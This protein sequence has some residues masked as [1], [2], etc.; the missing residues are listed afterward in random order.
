[1]TERLD[2]KI[3][4]PS[5]AA[6]NPTA[7]T[8]ASD[9]LPVI[10]S[11]EEEPYT[12]KC[13]CDYSDDD[14]NTIYC[15]SCDTWQH[16][17]CYYPGRVE[18]ASKDDFSHFCADCKPQ[19][20][21]DS[22]RATER[23][24]HNRQNKI[25]NDNGDKKTKRPPSKSHKKKSKPSELQVNGFVDHDSHR[26]GSP[27]EHHTHAKKTKGHR[28]NQSVSSA[29]KRS[30]PF[31]SRPHPHAHPPSPAHTPPDLP[32]TFQVHGYSEMFLSLYDHEYT[33]S[34]TNS[35]ASLDVTNSMSLWVHD[36]AKLEEDTRYSRE[37]VFQHLKVPIDSL[38]WQ[39]LRL[40]R[41]DGTFN[42]TA[43]H[44]RFLVAPSHTQQASR[45][46][47]LNGFIGFQHKYSED[48][49]ARWHEAP[50]PQ[51]F[52]FFH[53]RL[54]LYIDT[55]QEGSICR[56][57]RRSCRANASLET[58]I[59]ESSEYHFWLISE[60]QI[61]AGEQL[62]IPWD[63]RFPQICKSRYLRLLNL[64]DEDGSHSDNAE[65]TDEEYEGL[66][67]VIHLV[68]SDHGGCACDLGNDC[69]FARFHRSY[70]ARSHSQSNGV[71][72]KKSRKVKQNH[73]SPT[74][75]G[76]ATN[77]RAASEG[78]GEAYDEED[79]RSTSGSTR[80]K[81]QS[82]DLT[83]SH[84]MNETN[85]ILTEPTDREKRKLAML[86][87]SF[88]K[89]E[90]GQPP[91]KKK[92]VSDGSNVAVLIHT[93]TPQSKPRQKSVARM[94]ISQ[95]GASTANSQRARQYADASTSRRQSGSPFSAVSPTGAAHSPSNAASRN[96]SMAYQS[97][98]ASANPKAVYVDAETQ[99]EEVE[100]AWWTKPPT[101]PKRAVVPL[102]QRL[103]RNRRKIQAQQDIQNARLQVAIGDALQKDQSSPTIPMD[104][105]NLAHDDRYQTES[106]T[107]TKGR[108]VSISS[109]TTSVDVS[110]A[111]DTTM[112]DA[113]AVFIANQIKPPPPPWPH[114]IATVSTH[115]STSPTQRSPD[116][117]L[118]LPPAP[119][120][121]SPHISGPLSASA[122]PSSASASLTQSPF[123]TTFP[124]ASI[125]GL[126]Q[127]AS[128][129]KTTKK[130]SL[131]DYRAAR[132]RKTDT[133][134][135]SKP[136]SGSSPT[137]IPASLKPSLSTIEEVKAQ[138][139]LEG[140]AIVDSPMV[141]RTT[142]PLATVAATSE[143]GPK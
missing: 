38:K 65:I 125:N 22:R 9:A 103:L 70:H 3:A 39:E 143:A 115:K 93:S 49:E 73:V 105:D 90:Q 44:W 72:T 100:N 134:N 31:S 24:K 11:A 107:D 114:Q 66:S 29:M 113:P 74:S 99:T 15:E 12:I 16:T 6:Y 63:F 86:E 51:P 83:P 30:P 27:Q 80:S 75:T 53:P 126:V 132:M 110:A 137:V 94:S 79:N 43:L 108:N 142:N 45:I 117:Q 28:S 131:S 121:P 71:K 76:H 133:T 106:P 21:L 68:L 58:F 97:R 56:H 41:K 52:V 128:P 112:M 95:P 102:A 47:E 64:G 35:F 14:G 135:G 33:S 127:H 2:H 138:G 89:M 20:E 85:G 26:N 18:D 60:R 98:Q 69:A 57:V 91:R 129:V 124:G 116:L 67:Q 50:H 23:Q 84:G 48:P 1:M 10:E 25:I 111:T 62:T 36:P 37:D 19:P 122:T 8:T 55:R 123:G 141:E 46:A 130:L 61:A 13:I 96:G 4:T 109:S 118:Q 101:R 34:S 119:T 54:P 104:L 120:F 136:S 140:S 81:P 17:E 139:I 92:R 88:R 78:Q 87:D 82:R 42:D 32:S 77:S 40:I 5:Q 59:A 7:S